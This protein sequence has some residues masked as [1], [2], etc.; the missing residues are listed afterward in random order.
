MS[1]TNQ[2][3]IHRGHLGDCRGSRAATPSDF[4]LENKKK[5]SSPQVD[6]GLAPP[7]EKAEM[8]N[9]PTNQSI[10]NPFVV[11]TR[12]KNYKSTLVRTNLQLRTT[13][14][15]S[16]GNS[17]PEWVREWIK[18]ESKRQPIKFTLN[19]VTSGLRKV[20]LHLLISPK[21][22]KNR[23]NSEGRRA[24]SWSPLFF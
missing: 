5:R 13:E 11:C 23:E 7:L 12:Q 16:S 3:T 20:P 9:Q 8:T 14:G 4:G 18:H 6:R 17:E 15:V 24:F 10:I 19:L 2:P 21:W 1:P 22:R